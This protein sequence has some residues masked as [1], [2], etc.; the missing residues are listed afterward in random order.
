MPLETLKKVGRSDLVSLLELAQRSLE[1]TTSEH[2]S[3]LMD[4]VG[5]LVPVDNMVCGLA[6]IGPDEKF[7]S[8]LTVVDVSYPSGWMDLYMEKGYAR[9]DP[10]FRNHFSRYQTQIW[11]ETFAR[12][13]SAE[14]R[15]FLKEAG[16]FGLR[17]GVTLGI[18]SKRPSVAS[19][20]SFNGNKLAEHPQHVALLEYLTPH[21]HAAL[22]ASSPWRAIENSPRL[23][24]RER[25]I[26]QWTAI[27]KTNWEISAILGISERTVKFHIRNLMVKLGVSTRT[28]MVALALRHRL[29]EL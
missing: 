4:S 18:S 16:S 1:V 19:L 24:S 10:I 26:L 7:Q 2:F 28:H 20:F 6:N 17:E 13:K 12:A 3:M 11:S 27:G 14:E 29:I 25:E 9:I 23:S 22:V 15:A 21:L 8:I 5:S